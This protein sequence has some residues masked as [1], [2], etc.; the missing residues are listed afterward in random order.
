MSA[1]P[2]LEPGLVIVSGG[3]SGLAHEVRAGRHRLPADEPIEVGGT[4]TGPSPYDYLLAAL[5]PCTAM[6]LRLYAGRK[7]AAPQRPRRQRLALS[8]RARRRGGRPR[9]RP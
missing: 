4:D 2:A 5:G 8:R 1:P 6:T 7:G 3:P 9:R